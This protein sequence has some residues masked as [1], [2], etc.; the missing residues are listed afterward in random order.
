[1]LKAGVIRPS[2]SPWRA[3]V[4]LPQKKDGSRRFAVDYR[5]LNAV[6]PLDSYPLPSMED[7]LDRLNGSSYFST[8]DLKSA[9]W[10]IPIEEGDIPKTAFSAGPGLGLYEF[11]TMPF[12]LNGAP[13]T[14]QRLMDIILKDSKNALA[15]LDDIIIFSPDRRSHKK[16]LRGTLDLLEK[17]NI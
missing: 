5:Q 1:M 12:G 10:Q 9:Y 3:A 7:M 11:T 13:A 8:L 15:Y 2:S 17:A 4:T 6:V 16:H 14:C